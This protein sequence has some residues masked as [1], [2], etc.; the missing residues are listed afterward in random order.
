MAIIEAP[1]VGSIGLE[2]AHATAFAIMAAPV[3]RTTL[4]LRTLPE[5][6]RQKR[7]AKRAIKQRGS[8]TE[9]KEHNTTAAT[10]TFTIKNN[11]NAFKVV[12]TLYQEGGFRG[13]WRGTLPLGIL[14]F[15]T[16]Q[17]T[18]LGHSIVLQKYCPREVY[19]PNTDYAIQYTLG[20]PGYWSWLV[21]WS[22]VSV[23]MEVLSSLVVHP[24][25][26]L[27]TRYITD[28]PG[29]GHLHNPDSTSTPTGSSYKVPAAT[30]HD[31]SEHNRSAAWNTSSS[32]Y[33]D[34]YRYK[35]VC[36][37]IRQSTALPSISS[38]GSSSPA[39]QLLHKLRRLYKGW[40][41]CIPSTLVFGP[42][43]QVMTDSLLYFLTTRVFIF[44][45]DE[46]YSMN[47]MWFIAAC[48]GMQAVLLS[49]GVYA[50]D[51]IQYRF[52]VREDEEQEEIEETVDD[53]KGNNTSQVLQQK[54]FATG[55][56]FY[57]QTAMTIVED[58]GWL[59]LWRGFVLI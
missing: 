59:S 7:R 42:I 54:T 17:I 49:I 6:E 35:N 38:S 32:D 11:M 30:S 52:M 34:S 56:S 44:K 21:R 33:R 28:R 23:C 55:L 2:L 12:K 53:V 19:L 22:L 41:L 18:K 20:V 15:S 45:P 10:T 5:Y 1:Q 46:G 58:E 9:E 57:W 25:S 13:L 27:Y 36:D 47:Q 8:E 48:L 31:I 29:Y 4:I 50:V 14:Y 26:L 51:T 39:I 16:V 43:N 24:I 3:T 40:L 37:L